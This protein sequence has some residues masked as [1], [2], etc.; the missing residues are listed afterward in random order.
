MRSRSFVESGAA[1]DLSM[2]PSVVTRVWLVQAWAGQEFMEG[3][4]VG[5]FVDVHPSGSLW[6]S[7]RR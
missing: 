5:S 2:M 4:F 1:N 7:S 6:V 3:P